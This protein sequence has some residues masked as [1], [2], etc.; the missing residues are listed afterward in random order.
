MLQVD[1]EISRKEGEG[2]E[3][4]FH[5]DATLKVIEGNAVYLEAPNAK[6]KSSLLNIL[7]IS[8]YGHKLEGA[9]SRISP[10][11]KSN[12]K[13]M[14]ERENQKFTFNVRFSSK[15]GSIQLISSKLNPNNNDITI[16]EINNGHERILPFQ[17]FRDEYYLVYDIPENPL[18]RLKEIVVEVDHQ[19]D[20]Y[21]K[22]VSDFKRYLEEIKEQLARSRDENAIQ[23]LNATIERYTKE[24]ELL[25]AN[26]TATNE[27]IG[28]IEPFYVLRE[29]IHYAKLSV[30]LED[31]IERKNQEIKKIEKI[32]RKHDKV[33]PQKRKEVKELIDSIVQSISV[34][35]V[36]LRN[37]FI[38]SEDMRLH[39]ED[40]KNIDL[41]RAIETYGLDPTIK[42]ELEYVAQQIY[43]YG[44]TKEIKEA[45][46]KGEFFREILK[47]LETYRGIDVSI[48]GTGKSIEELIKL[49]QSEYE[50]NR[51]YTE[52][53][54]RLNRC[55]SILAQIY[56]DLDKLPKQLETLKIAFKKQK[57]TS[58]TAPEPLDV[59]DEIE[60]I[61][62]DLTEVLNK[63]QRYSQI[64]ENHG[65][66]VHEMGE[67]AIEEK[68][69]QIIGKNK[70][71]MT[72]FQQDEEKLSETL[73]AFNREITQKES[74]VKQLQQKIAQY[75][76]KLS[77]LMNR[78]KHKYDAYVS[79]IERI[80]NLV[81][82]LE[83][84]LIGYGKVLNKINN[85]ET[86][87]TDQ[88]IQYN[89]QI[90]QY[91]ALKIPQFPY[92]GDF[93][94]PK[95]IDFILKKIY[96]D[97][98]REIDMKDISTGQAMSMYIQAILNRPSDDNR[99]LI[100]IFDEASTMDSNSFQPIK[101]TLKRLIDENKLIF[102]LFARAVDG[103][104]RLTK[105]AW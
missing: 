30:S 95:K 105:I 28:V 86:L 10:T 56:L 42:I 68:V 37:I 98:G 75:D 92:I 18:N 84:D 15:D 51:D 82:S 3:L 33:Y 79:E 17:V 64:A 27:K 55:S 6:G 89:E 102:A 44:E 85:G 53:Y 90:S 7:A 14:T 88:E 91:L 1:Y 11:L 101:S 104:T 63:V 47:I 94:R 77:D 100:V 5:P 60:Q 29:F 83:F 2:K 8:M 99:K 25:E 22:K 61:S 67:A 76:Q 93:I 66:N 71:Y 40:I 78:E 74:E 52:I 103:E 87:K 97:T 38:E 9:D 49:I 59:D 96:T 34:L 19:Q 41:Y 45:G 13:Y 50:W 21:K 26:I 43:S 23:D 24:L 80:S 4:T 72:I 16:R 31:R 69:Q 20:R 65:L 62:H 54:T 32:K 35:T 58:E 36:H 12:I 39:I 70:H 57:E 48:P 46:K 73:G 81:D